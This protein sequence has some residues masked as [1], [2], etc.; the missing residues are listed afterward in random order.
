[1]DSR[2]T[3]S[4]SPGVP[5]GSSK[6]SESITWEVQH[7]EV[8]A[9]KTLHESTHNELLQE[10]LASLRTLATDLDKDRWRYE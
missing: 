1:M 3:S 5:T 7:M 8:Q 2:F 9:T 4:T 10:T 6:R